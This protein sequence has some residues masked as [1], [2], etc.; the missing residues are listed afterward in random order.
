MITCILAKFKR[1]LRALISEIRDWV[2]RERLTQIKLA[3][4]VHCSQSAVSRLFDREPKYQTQLLNRICILAKIET[5]IP[6]DLKEFPT[7][8]RAL[9]EVWDG[10]TKREVAIAELLRAAKNVTAA[11]RPRRPSDAEDDSTEGG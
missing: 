9:A 6:F 2:K 1:P 3:K 8:G 5:H 11:D 7:L 4:K 10:S